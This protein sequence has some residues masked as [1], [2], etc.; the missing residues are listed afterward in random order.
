VLENLTMEQVKNATANAVGSDALIDTSLRQFKSGTV[1]NYGF[2]IYNA[3]TDA[4]RVPNLTSQIRVFRDG[5]PL[6]EGKPQSVT[7]EGKSDTKAIARNG[8]LVLG[9]KIMV[10]GDYVLE[11]AITDNLAKTKNNTSVQYVQFEIVE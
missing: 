5:K 9:T 7:I 10:P 6:F 1:L 3:K 2:F 11:I 4:S 8:S